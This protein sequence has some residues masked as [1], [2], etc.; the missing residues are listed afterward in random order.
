MLSATVHGRSPKNLT[1]S[2]YF[3]MQA[4]RY[5]GRILNKQ[6]SGFEGKLTKDKWMK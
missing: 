6:F 2:R 4:H 1:E 3:D 5:K